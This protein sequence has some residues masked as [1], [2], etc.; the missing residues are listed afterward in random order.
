[1][2]CQ[3]A[4]DLMD[5]ALEGRLQP[6]LRPGFEEHMAEC[7]PCA[8]YFQHLHVTREALRNL[9][10]DPGRSGHRDELIDRF[11]RRFGKH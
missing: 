3:E 2:E 5:Q 4:I 10:A 9:P 11:K 8:T 1:V 7:Q 6:T